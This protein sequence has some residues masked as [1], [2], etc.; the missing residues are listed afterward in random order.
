MARAVLQRKQHGIRTDQPL[1][2]RK[3]FLCQIRFG[4]Q[5]DQIHRPFRLSALIYRHMIQGLRAVSLQY[6][7][8][9]IDL[10][11]MRRI[12]TDQDDLR[13]SRELRP[14]Q[15]S[16]SAGTDHRNLHFPLR[17]KAPRRFAC[18]ISIIKIIAYPPPHRKIKYS[19]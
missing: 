9:L 16:H 14:V 7:A 6:D 19:Y 13:A 15:K 4:E 10:S 18:L 8:I 11:P 5:D 2:L 1:V 3:R 12:I 17:S